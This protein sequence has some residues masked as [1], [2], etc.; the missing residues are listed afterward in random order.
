MSLSQLR[1]F[2]PVFVLAGSTASFGQYMDQLRARTDAGFD[3]A[4]LAARTSFEALAGYPKDVRDAVLTLST[5]PELIVKLNEARTAGGATVD[6]V[7]TPYGAD[8]V[9]AARVVSA[10][11]ELIQMLVDRLPVV[12]LMGQCVGDQMPTVR[13]ILDRESEVRAT[14]TRGL[15]DSWRKRA[16]AK[17]ILIDQ[18]RSA[19]ADFTASQT[20]LQPIG[21]DTVAL[22]DHPDAAVRANRD[23]KLDWVA[24]ITQHSVKP[25]PVDPGNA[26][27]G[28]GFSPS[29]A[30]PVTGLP[31]HDEVYFTLVHSDK[32]PE[33]AGAVVEQW[34]FEHNPD[35]FRAAVDAWYTAY[36][37]TL[38]QSLGGQGDELPAILKERMRFEK[39]YL[40]AMRDPTAKRMYRSE[41][42]DAN[43]SEFPALTRVRDGEIIARL[44]DTP[45]RVSGGPVSKSTRSGS[46]GGRSSS[47]QSS[48]STSGRTNRASTNRGG[49]RGGATG[50]VSGV[51]SGTRGTRGNNSNSR[52]SGQGNFGSSG[53]R[54]SNSGF[55]N[56]G[57]G[58]S[59]F[60][61][62]GG[63]GGF[64][65]SSGG[66]GG[67]SGGFGGSSGGFGGGSGNNSSRFNNN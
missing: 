2:V 42:L 6:S 8:A 61:G 38:P 63:G 36:Q 28:F 39:R 60:G 15:V 27:S 21:P 37:E 14:A 26:A 33:L 44:N 31:G 25:L 18:L 22:V 67:S 55:G 56:S 65:G 35:G 29:A 47:G 10:R 12:T 11:P 46:G 34:Y 3:A 7:A 52:G 57:G 41:F 24:G 58:S 64:G 1:F 49:G 48:A 5:R 17:P 59:G 43:T 40:A 53:N 51:A 20:A 13:A 16:T 9:V 19:S 62:S 32:Y 30:P 23:D 66:F 50:D 54:R 4:R 45:D